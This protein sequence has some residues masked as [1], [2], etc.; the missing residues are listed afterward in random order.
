MQVKKFTQIYI[1]SILQMNNILMINSDVKNKK[2]K[3]TF[4]INKKYGF[5][6]S[7]KN[8]SIFLSGKNNNPFHFIQ[9]LYSKRNKPKIQLETIKQLIF[10]AIDIYLKNSSNFKFNQSF[11]IRSK[12]F[13]Q[14]KIPIQFTKNNIYTIDKME[15]MEKFKDLFNN[16]YF[17]FIYTILTDNMQ[18]INQYDKELILQELYV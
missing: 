8:V 18:S 4:N 15:L 5:P 14:I 11:I 7:Y 2:F 10:S 17:C 3:Y 1:Q 9:R 12:K 6:C 16:Q 13:P